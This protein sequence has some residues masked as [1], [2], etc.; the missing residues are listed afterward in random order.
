MARVVETWDAELVAFGLGL[1]DYVPFPLSDWA[2]GEH[3]PMHCFGL[4][5]LLTWDAR[6]WQDVLLWKRFGEGLMLVAIL[7]L[8][9]AM[10]H[11]AGEVLK[12]GSGLYR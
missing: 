9:G 2:L 6:T 4:V 3:G 7:A 1:A 8:D 10:K 5:F 11:L 12:C